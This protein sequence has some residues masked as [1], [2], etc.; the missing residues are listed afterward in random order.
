MA[1]VQIIFD[2]WT[3]L[4]IQAFTGNPVPTLAVAIGI[5][6]MPEEYNPEHP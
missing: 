3:I 2:I 5:V 4:I 6:F 1:A